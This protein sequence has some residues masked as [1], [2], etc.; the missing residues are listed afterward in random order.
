MDDAGQNVTTPSNGVTLTVRHVA[1]VEITPNGSA[2]QPGQTVIGRPGQDGVLT[3]LIRNP[4]NG[5]DI[6]T[7]DT[8]A[9][10]GVTSALVTY[11][12]DD[13]D[14]RFDPDKDSPVSTVSLQPDEERVLF[15]TYPVPSGAQS[16]ATFVFG[17]R[18]TSGVDQAVTDRDNFGQISTQ[19]VLSLTF[20]AS[21]NGTSTSPGSVTYTHELHNTGNA[22]LTAQA[23]ALTDS[24][25]A[26]SYA[27]QI[28]D[29]GAASTLQDA[30]ALWNGTLASGQRLPI[31]VTVTAPT[32]LAGGVQDT[33]QLGASI[34]TPSSET[35]DNQTPAPLTLTDV[36]MILKGVPSS[37]KTVQS[38]GQ[39]ATCAAPVSITDGLVQPNEYLLYTI[40]GSNGGNGGLRRPILKDT[41]P[42]HL[43]GV[44]FRGVASLNAGQLLYSLDGQSWT[45]QVPSIQDAEG[46]T[47][48]LGWD[49]NSDGVVTSEDV[50]PAGE[51]LTLTLITAVK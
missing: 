28:G 46:V 9:Q 17:P 19:A 51:G 15:A 33:L 35:V 14:G 6:Y 30:L 50:L 37:A 31:R 44:T 21:Q 48:Y 27:Y 34:V 10:P 16:G 4:S 11:W 43:K 1:A 5:N 39:D 26:W 41:L 47:V 38:C 32:G 29:A 42:Q 24:G 20:S 8:Q 12:A 13:G 23:L 49:S 25:G 2:T 45:L 3:Y 22:P 36:T 18:A 7:L 40:T